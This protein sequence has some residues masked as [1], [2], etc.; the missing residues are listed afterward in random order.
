MIPAF[1]K[2]LGDLRAYP[3]RTL[4]VVCALTLGLLGLGAMRVSQF[5]L[6]SDLNEN[7][8][9][10]QPFHVALTSAD[11]DKLDLNLLRRMPEIERAEYRDL[12]LQRIEVFPGKW[13]PLWLYGVED[14]SH[15][16][17]AK[18]YP[19]SGNATPPRGSILMERNGQLVSSLGTGTLAPVRAGSRTLQVPISGI[20]FDPAQAPATQDAFI[21]A[22]TDKATYSSISGEAANRR[23]ILR[24]K[25]AQSR[26][27]V[28]T[29]VNSIVQALGR[30]GI[31]IS[32]TDIPKF[33]QHPHQFQLNTLLTF[34]ASIGLLAFV[35][36]AVLVSQLV[37]AIL[38]QQVRQ[39]GVMKAIGATRWQ[40]M[41]IY[42]FMVLLLGA[43]A[44]I[45]AIPLAVAAGYGFA[46]FVAKILNFDILTRTLPWHLYAQLIAGGLILP[47]LFALP[48]LWKGT[49]ISVR[50]ALAD[51]GIRDEAMREQSNSGARLPLS[52]RLAWRNV[53]RRK[54]KLA[55]SVATIALGVAIFNAGFNVRQSL[56]D[57]LEASKRSMRYDVQLVLKQSL[58]REQALAPFAGMENVE[59]IDAWN[60]GR[61]RLQSSV[62][63]TAKGIGLVAMP[64]DTAL[65][66]MTVIQGRWLQDAGELEIVMNQAAADD[67]GEPT[68]IGKQYRISLN[69]RPATVR[70]VGIV[71]EFDAA[72]IYI[73]K[74]QYDNYANPEHLVNSLL[75][76]AKDRRYAEVAKLKQA[77]EARIAGSDFD[78][79]YVM[80]QSERA[81]I[82][83][84]HLNIILTLFS[85][86]SLLVLTISALGM[87]AVMGASILERTR[88]IG[89]MRAIGAT[90]QAVYRIF[91]IE[92][93]FISLG[94]MV[95]GLLLGLPLSLLA[96]RFFGSLILGHDV[97]LDFAFSLH[98]FVITLV[99]TL[100]FGW[101][102]SRIPAQKA[103]RV[104]NREALAYE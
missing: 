47:L 104:P 13:L 39:V 18:I 77:V 99:I 28:E 24:L 72:K 52:A 70:L 10:T 5:V 55:I 46:G 4:L 58:P 37:D 3:G 54:R 2:A 59:L 1:A 19:Q 91:E 82:V 79:L 38:A 44:S 103:V 42:L 15:F 34:Q 9:R 81:K 16:E 60:G 33:N 90:P 22:Y 65:V 71:R 74:T 35:L 6:N 26:L 62:V 17:L 66:Q 31:A 27:E 84:D 68:E 83:F 100:L 25:G 30:Q 20:V 85:A 97:A 96:A 93:A 40:V 101:L 67:F 76:V 49:H 48:T 69:G 12:S 80:S 41:R 23:L 50:Q 64:R 8:L 11:F 57:F 88:E 75:F 86:L 102:A 56:L 87:G 51:Y 43:L 29:A 21:Y 89:V 73:D 32:S 7:F 98:G 92:G 61:G 45:I 94:G 14:F 95:L 63:S 78:V 36:G 53:L